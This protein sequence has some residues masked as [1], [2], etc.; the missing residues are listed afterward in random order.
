MAIPKKRRVS[1]LRRREKLCAARFK[2]SMGAIFPSS[3]T[4]WTRKFAGAVGSR[5]ND[6]I[7]DMLATDMPYEASGIFFSLLRLA[8]ALRR[9]H[10][11]WCA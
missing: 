6:L 8:P 10:H 7:A 1:R 4:A 11:Q 9:Q 2:D 5:A 3:A